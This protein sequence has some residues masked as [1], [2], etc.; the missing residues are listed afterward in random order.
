MKGEESSMLSIKWWHCRD[1]PNS[2]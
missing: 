2:P 1:D